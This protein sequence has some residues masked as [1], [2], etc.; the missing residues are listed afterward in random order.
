MDALQH[1]A[2]GVAGQFK[3]CMLG[4]GGEL[5]SAFLELEFP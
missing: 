4:N 1:L 2:G 5:Q 3:L